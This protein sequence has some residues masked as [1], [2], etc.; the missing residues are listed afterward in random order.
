MKKILITGA[1]GF[2]GFHLAKK[3]AENNF[4]IVG[5]DNLNSYYDVS[6]KIDR[7][8]QLGVKTQANITESI[9]VNSDR[10]PNLFFHR[11]DITD[12]KALNA[13]FEE[14]GFDLVINLAAQ[15]G[16]RYSIQN[17]RAY[18]QS[19]LVG[20]ANILE[21]C[22]HFGVEK[23]IYASSSSVYG[24]SVT[25]PF[26]ETDT[27]DLPVSLY[28]ATK[29]S[30]ELMAHTY[31]HLFGIST[32]GLR[33]FTVYGP[34]GR[35]DMAPFLFAKAINNN[36]TIKVFNGGDLRRDF[37]YIEDII[38]GVCGIVD[39]ISAKEFRIFNIGNNKPVKLMDFI[40]TLSA[41]IGKKPN[42][43]MYPMQPGDVYQTYADISKLN[44]YCN[45][46]PKFGIEQ[47]VSEFVAWYQNY[48]G[49]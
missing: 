14:Y 6:L 2:I 44:S 4:F 27:V 37:T 34:W 29:K 48:Y 23:L 31:T 17:P 32:I 10:Y 38:D 28:A 12:A 1:A 8:E 43:E 13:I 21:A 35:P 19:N 47:G 49:N 7:L 15:A 42:L 41:E 9:K 11:L 16:V 36:E 30:N 22:R 45:F 20:F 40:S 46:K 3:L 33:F 25:T 5:I 18:I 39:N 24:N 26:K